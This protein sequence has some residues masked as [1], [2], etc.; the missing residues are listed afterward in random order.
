ML[1]ALYPAFGGGYEEPQNS[2]EQSKESSTGYLRSISDKVSSMLGDDGG[3]AYQGHPGATDM[4][5]DGNMGGRP[6]YPPPNSSYGGPQTYGG[7][8]DNRP[9]GGAYESRS[10]GGMQGFGSGPDPRDEKT[11]MQKIGDAAAT[12]KEK[13]S[14]FRSSGPDAT[15]RFANDS[16]NFNTY[17]SNRGMNAHGRETANTYSP[18]TTYNGGSTTQ[19]SGGNTG[20]YGHSSQQ[21]PASVPSTTTPAAG[22]NADVGIVPEMPL[23]PGFGRAGSAASDGSYEQGLIAGLCEPGG[24]KA[25]PPQDKLAKFLKAAPT[26]SADLVGTCLMNQLNED[27]W[28]TRV[29]ALMVVSSLCLANDCTTHMRWWSSSDQIEELTTISR[30]DPKASVRSQASKTL[31]NLSGG[32]NNSESAQEGLQPP[33]SGTVVSHQRPVSLLDMDEPPVPAPTS[34]PSTSF[35]QLSISQPPPQAN[36]SSVPVAPVSN[37]ASDG[38]LFEGMDMGV[39]S[40][41]LVPFQHSA[42]VD[43]AIL[44]V[45]HD[46]NV[47]ASVSNLLN[48]MDP[49]AAASSPSVPKPSIGSSLIDIEP[50]VSQPQPTNVF[51][52]LEPSFNNGSQNPAAPATGM[53]PVAPQGG[54]PG[55]PLPPYH[56]Q[57]GMPNYGQNP[58]YMA[59]P[60]PSGPPPG[61][62]GAYPPYGNHH[63]P[64]APTR[65]VGLM[66]SPTAGQRKHIPDQ[67]EVRTGSSTSGILVLLILGDFVMCVSVG[68]SGFSFMGGSKAGSNGDSFSFVGDA[69]KS[70][71]GQK[72]R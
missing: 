59:Y 60:G 15:V 65:Q 54:Y 30:S 10:S 50:V 12:A 9:G 67:D 64:Q 61:G 53:Y 37:V 21:P 40:E 4:V 66:G 24:M 6:S 29:K 63:P 2:R 27:S 33:L 39:S 7:P 17:N 49:F 11:W 5:S 43:N 56:G 19:L 8:G 1:W 71:K 51:A 14:S 46:P 57:Q 36:T 31:R 55:Q 16:T 38:G 44:S 45:A 41:P 70:S 72:N 47:V 62:Y 22:S 68:S 58:S 20:P 69:M 42:A 28:Q 26:L 34:D 23:R 48:D 13:V 3:G 52:D 18:S 35:D 25:V 32:A